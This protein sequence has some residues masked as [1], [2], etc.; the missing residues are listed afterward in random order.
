[1]AVE[2]GTGSPAL[3]SPVKKMVVSA[4][5]GVAA[6][7]ANKPAAQT[8]DARMENLLKRRSEE[9]F[10]R[11]RFYRLLSNHGGFMS[12]LTPRLRGAAGRDNR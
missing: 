11:T 5:A 1:V 12:R 3:D 2:V 4:E 10:P 8:K 6:A 7:S 9:E